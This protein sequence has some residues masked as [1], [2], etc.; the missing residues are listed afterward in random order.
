MTIYNI[1]LTITIHAGSI[2]L[3]IS[4]VFKECSKIYRK[5]DILHGRTQPCLKRLPKLFSVENKTLTEVCWSHLHTDGMEPNGHYKTSRGTK[6]N[7]RQAKSVVGRNNWHR[8][9]QVKAWVSSLSNLCRTYS[10]QNKNIGQPLQRQTL[11]S[12]AIIF[13]QRKAL[14]WYHHSWSGRRWIL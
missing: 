11:N 6:H 3:M 4:S 2:R 5:F 1:S 13:W 14:E 7:L 12:A 8:Q 9:C 10:L